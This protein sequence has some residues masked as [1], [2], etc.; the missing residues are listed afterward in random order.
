LGTSTQPLFTRPR[1]PQ[2]LYVIIDGHFDYDQECKKACVSAGTGGAG[3]STSTASSGGCGGSGGSGPPPSCGC[4]TKA[5]TG[6]YNRIYKVLSTDLGPAVDGNKPALAGILLTARWSDLNPAKHTYTFGPGASVIG[7]HLLDDAFSAVKDFNAACAAGSLP[8]CSPV[9]V[10]LAIYPG[11]STPDWVFQEMD[12]PGVGYGNC[13]GLFISPP[14]TPAPSPNCEYTTIFPTIEGTP[15]GQPMRLPMPWSVTYQKYWRTFLQKLSAVY[16]GYPELVSIAIAGPTA[17]SEEMMLPD[18]SNEV[19]PLSLACS[20]DP[21][22]SADSAWETLIL[23][24]YGFTLPD[25]CQVDLNTLTYHCTDQAFVDAWNAAIDMYG[26]TFNG[27]SLDLTA[28]P[29]LPALKGTTMTAPPGF[30]KMPCGAS[31]MG[32]LAMKNVLAHYLDPCV[33]TGNGKLI[34]MDALQPGVPPDDPQ[35]VAFRTRTG[36]LSVAGST[37][38]QVSPILAGAQAAGACAKK[39]DTYTNYAPGQTPSPE[40]ACFDMMAGAFENTRAGVHYGFPGGSDSLNYI[41]IWE[42]DITYATENGE[43]TVIPYGG[44]GGGTGG[45]SP[46]M[47]SMKEILA[48]AALHLQDTT[49]LVPF[50]GTCPPPVFPHCGGDPST[51]M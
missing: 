10:Q 11:A 41:Q 50:A 45:G 8:G 13:D 36:S 48:K 14:P 40:Q 30:D 25:G 6:L 43:V 33:A 29:I 7:P 39:W 19:E 49:D 3:G 21:G 15:K 35:W 46:V 26:A 27:L 23:N 37:P 31:P 1:S 24:R 17:Q 16:N 22:V 18:D 4:P 28:L 34:Q 42:G 20:P 12:T 32:C 51:C 47:L 38:I 2:G 44:G 9:T 5:D